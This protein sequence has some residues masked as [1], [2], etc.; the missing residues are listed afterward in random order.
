MKRKTTDMSPKTKIILNP[1]YAALRQFLLS[2]PEKMDKEGE[3][4]YGGRRN[5]IKMFIAPGGTRLNVKRYHKPHGLNSLVYSLHL[6]TPKG[7]R[8]FRYAGILA[9]KEINTPE[10]VA[11]IEQRKGGILILSYFI[12]VQSPLTHLLYEMGNAEERD[13]QPMAAALAHF[14]ADMHQKGVL[15]KDFSPGNILFERRETGYEFSI[16]DINRM[17]FG[18][19][20]LGEGCAS[21]RRLWGPKRFIQSLCREYARLRGEDEDEAERLTMRERRKFW[22]GYVKKREMEFPLE[23]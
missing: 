20:S 13:W 16:V 2:L 7:E 19:V 1:K 4:I 8:A 9:Q 18:K 10:P 15:H 14:A 3:Y 23:L 6:R 11:Y 17:R 12:S 21:F 5:L 22:Q